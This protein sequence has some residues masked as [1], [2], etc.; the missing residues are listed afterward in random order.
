MRK[1][2][3]ATA[4]LLGMPSLVFAQIGVIASGS[5]T[6]GPNGSTGGDTSL[7]NVDVQNLVWTPFSTINT[8]VTAGD[9]VGGGPTPTTTTTLD[10]DNI[11]MIVTRDSTGASVGSLRVTIDTLNVEFA[12]RAV[13]TGIGS[14]IGA[15]Y[16]AATSSPLTGLGANNSYNSVSFSLGSGG[17]TRYISLRFWTPNAYSSAGGETFSWQLVGPI[18]NPIIR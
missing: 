7:V 11:R 18:A 2:L 12:P 17:P 3:F 8:N 10:Y 6:L 1:L 14:S 5:F 9:T 13:G 16:T 15:T 4:F